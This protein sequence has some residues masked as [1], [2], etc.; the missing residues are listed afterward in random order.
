MIKQEVR[1]SN[2]SATLFKV[3]EQDSKRF[4]MAGVR[5]SRDLLLCNKQGE[6]LGVATTCSPGTGEMGTSQNF[7]CDSVSLTK[8]GTKNLLALNRSMYSIPLSH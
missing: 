4:Q 6:T 2:Y 8:N 7:R 1:D 5:D 3:S